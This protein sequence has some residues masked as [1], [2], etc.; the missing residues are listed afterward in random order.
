LA[1]IEAR[2]GSCFSKSSF[3]HVVLFSALMRRG[4]TASAKP[5]A[6]SAPDILQERVESSQLFV[7]SMFGQSSYD[8]IDGDGRAKLAT[9]E[10][11]AML[12][13]G[14]VSHS[15]TSSPMVCGCT[16]CRVLRRLNGRPIPGNVHTCCL[17]HPNRMFIKR[18]RME[19]ASLSEIA[20][21]H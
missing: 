18:L 13:R 16:P 1:D 8:F 6:V 12:W 5:T 20:G 2:L 4:S 15:L 10:K 11:S 17:T 7:V 14:V 19:I 21:Y 3:E 9:G